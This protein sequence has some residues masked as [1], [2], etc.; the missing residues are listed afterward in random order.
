MR[1]STAQNWTIFLVDA[2]MLMLQSFVSIVEALVTIATLTIMRPSK[3]SM[4]FCVKRLELEVALVD[5][6]EERNESY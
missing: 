3:W 4:W 1:L 2:A 5:V 6:F